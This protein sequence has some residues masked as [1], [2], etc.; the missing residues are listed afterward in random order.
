MRPNSCVLAAI[1]LIL[2]FGAVI[3]SSS[4]DGDDFE[5]SMSSF[6][7]NLAAQ[8]RDALQKMKKLTYIQPITCSGIRCFYNTSLKY[9]KFSI[10]HHSRDHAPCRNLS[11]VSIRE[12][13]ASSNGS[14]ETYFESLRNITGTALTREAFTQSGVRLATSAKSVL[15][16]GDSIIDELRG[17]YQR[18]SG[19]KADTI[20]AMPLPGVASA[21]RALILEKLLNSGAQGNRFDMVF[22]GGLGLWHL[23]GTPC[24]GGED[25]SSTHRRVVHEHLLVYKNLSLDLGI[26]FVFV[27]SLPV[28][29]ATVFLSPPKHDWHDFSDFTLMDI[30]DAIEGGLFQR[31]DYG[32][33]VVHFR[34]S[35]IVRRCPGVRCDGIHFSADYWPDYSLEGSRKI[36][37]YRCHSSEAIWDP[38]LA[39]FLERTSKRAKAG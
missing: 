29:A 9:P 32:P 35:L 8:K 34:P 37:T 16:L 12:A 26:P 39:G 4:E 24:I 15:F 14:K 23:I 17:S 38:Y 2:V 6:S 5:G 11:L 33:G 19:G 27:G 18:V 21:T 28:D 7:S 36:V 25:P 3:S 13:L 1:K 30:W 10:T 31:N 20:R 22:A